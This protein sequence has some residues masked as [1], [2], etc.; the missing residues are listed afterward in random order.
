MSC[1]NTLPARKISSL[2]Q[3]GRFSCEKLRST[4]RKRTWVS[5]PR[6]RLSK[7]GFVNFTED[8]M[9]VSVWPIRI[10]HKKNHRA[11]DSFS[12]VSSPVI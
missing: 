8:V 4:V 7:K 12:P 3:A 9:C 1:H 2:T 5:E 11:S 6:H 10:N